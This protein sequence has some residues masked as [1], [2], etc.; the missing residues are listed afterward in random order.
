VKDDNVQWGVKPTTEQQRIPTNGAHV[1][2]VPRQFDGC[3]TDVTADI[4]D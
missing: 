1:S 3:I 4:V 2:L